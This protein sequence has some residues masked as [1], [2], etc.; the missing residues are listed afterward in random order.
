[1]E[2]TLLGTSTSFWAEFKSYYV[3]WKLQIAVRAGTALARFKSYYVVWKQCSSN[4]DMP[5][6]HE[7]KSYYVV[8]KRPN[9]RT[10]CVRECAGLNRTM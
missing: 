7:F 9:I 4:S 1:M 3:V 2:T 8:W 10:S 6:R 5:T